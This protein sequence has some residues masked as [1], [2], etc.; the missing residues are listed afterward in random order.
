[1]Q[2]CNQKGTFSTINLQSAYFVWSKMSMKGIVMLPGMNNTRLKR[3]ILIILYFENGF[4]PTYLPLCIVNIFIICIVFG[5]LKSS[6]IIL[7]DPNKNHMTTEAY[8]DAMAR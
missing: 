8:Y 3:T 5:L 7:N 6:K 2:F 1:M 4:L